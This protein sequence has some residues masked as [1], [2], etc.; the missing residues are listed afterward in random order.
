MLLLASRPIMI[1]C[2]IVASYLDY[3]TIIRIKVVVAV[4]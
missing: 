1:A 2:Q 4:E 3:E